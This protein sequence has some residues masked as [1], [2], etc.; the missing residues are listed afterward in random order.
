MNTRTRAWG[1]AYLAALA[2]PSGT[3][4][5]MPQPLSFSAQTVRQRVRLRR[6]GTALRLALS[7]EFGRQPLVIDE[8]TAVGGVPVLCH[9]SARW[10]IQ[11]GETVTSDPVPL[12]VRA[13]E[14]LVV[15]CYVSGAAETAAFLPALQRTGEAAPGTRRADVIS[16]VPSV[17]RPA[18]GS[19]A[20][21]PTSLCRAK[22]RSRT[23]TSGFR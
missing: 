23:L 22:T 19:R 20:C 2:D 16:T 13:D 9:G 18:T 4:P 8:V 5:F 21:L 12:S 17:S 1:T 11:P 15:D 6:G 14:E 3:P 10:Q 7:N